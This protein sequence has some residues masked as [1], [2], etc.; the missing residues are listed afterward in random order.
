M[1]NC[2]F[3]FNS[4]DM[5]QGWCSSLFKQQ[6]ALVCKLAAWFRSPWHLDLSYRMHNWLP[7]WKCISKRE[8]LR[9]LRCYIWCRVFCFCFQFLFWFKPQKDKNPNFNKSKTKIQTSISQKQKTKKQKTFFLQSV[10]NRVLNTL[11]LNLMGPNHLASDM[12]LSLFPSN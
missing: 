11:L 10:V 3:Y 5:Q 12:K 4:D 8:K 9:L 6:R 2:I 1:V 7:T